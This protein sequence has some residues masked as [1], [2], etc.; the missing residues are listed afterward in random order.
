MTCMNKELTEKYRAMT[1]S[2]LIWH[3]SRHKPID[4]QEMVTVL[5]ERLREAEKKL[6]E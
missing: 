3:A 5:L 1:N 2:Q 4:Q 6:N